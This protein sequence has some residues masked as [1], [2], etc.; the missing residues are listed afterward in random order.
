MKFQE[1]LFMYGEILPLTLLAGI[2]PSIHKVTGNQFKDEL[3]KQQQR[4][5]LLGEFN[6]RMNSRSKE[7]HDG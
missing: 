1:N 6:D 7:Y 4:T 2:L 5:E 3:E